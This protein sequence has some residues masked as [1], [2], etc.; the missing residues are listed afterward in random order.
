MVSCKQHKGLV[1][2]AGRTGSCQDGMEDSSK[3]QAWTPAGTDK[4]RR[5]RNMFLRPHLHQAG[6]PPERGEI[7]TVFEW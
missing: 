4:L 1:W 6:P 3:S 2:C 5:G 7:L